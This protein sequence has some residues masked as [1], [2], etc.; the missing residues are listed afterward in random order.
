MQPRRETSLLRFRKKTNFSS[1]PLK[2]EAKGLL[3]TMQYT[4]N[5]RF[6]SIMVDRDCKILFDSIQRKIENVFI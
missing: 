1:T 3:M 5:I 6:K 4:W 2:T